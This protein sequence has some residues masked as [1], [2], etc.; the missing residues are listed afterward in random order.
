MQELYRELQTTDRT[1]AQ[2]T[3]GRRHTEIVIPPGGRDRPAR[4]TF[5]RWPN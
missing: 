3:K 4:V 2:P 1:L 5:R